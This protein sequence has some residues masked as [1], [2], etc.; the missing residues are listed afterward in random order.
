MRAIGKILKVLLI[1]VFTLALILIAGVFA[2]LKWPQLVVNDRVF[3]A[4]A[5]LSGKFGVMIAWDKSDLRVQSESL[6]HKRFD[7]A[8]DRFCVNLSENR[9]QGCFDRIELHAELA[10]L[11]RRFQAIAMG[12]ILATGGNVAV[13]LDPSDPRKKKLGLDVPD[14]VLPDWF[15]ATRFGRVELELKTL[16]LRQDD[17]LLFNG[18]ARLRAE[19]NER[20]RL[21]TARLEAVSLP[22]AGWPAGELQAEVKSESS[23]TENDWLL[24]GTGRLNPTR[25]ASARFGISL[26]PAGTKVYGIRLQGDFRLG[27]SSGSLNLNGLLGNGRLWGSFSGEG[28]GF[29]A[30][31]HRVAANSCRYD[32]R[33]TKASGRLRFSL[34]CPVLVDTTPLRIPS[35]TFEKLVTLPYNLD[36]RV[37][38]DLETSFY[39]SW[40]QPV[41]GEL[42]IDLNT[43]SENLLTVEGKTKTAFAGTPSRYPQ[44]WKLETD[45][46]VK[47]LMSQFQKLVKAL[48]RTAFAIFAPVNNLDGSVELKFTGKAD[49]AR[50]QGKLPLEFTTRLRSADQAF[51]TDGKGELQ[52]KLSKEGARTR[53]ALDLML[54]DAKLV[55]PSFGYT[56]MPALF[57]DPRFQTPDPAAKKRGG[58]FDYEL[59]VKTP[60]DKP[61]HLVS[62]FAKENIPLH[63]D[64]RAVPDRLSGTVAVGPSRLDFFRRD[65]QVQ[66]FV[67]TLQE[68]RERS[69]VDGTVKIRYADYD[70]RI[71]VVGTFK[72]PRIIMESSPPLDQEQIISVLIYGRTF[73]ELS[74]DNANSV[75][76][77]SSAV[78]NRAITLGSLFLL[79]GTPIESVSYDPMTQTFTARVRIAEG[80]SLTV[81]T[82]EGTSPQAGLR[83][84]LGRNWIL[85]TYVEDDQ[86][87]KAVRGGAMI[88]YYKRY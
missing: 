78:A 71:M 38:T 46:D 7:F 36:L 5:H 53:I 75:G 6:L 33:E 63:L 18:S 72:R 20:A 43:V 51:D 27:E 3:R 41:N 70:I 23:F 19:P 56:A 76:A 28:R 87:A 37:R 16:A 81:G 61:A 74:T 68:P 11:Q 15:R 32:L 86:K 31:V 13:V 88:E 55:L 47:I 66:K 12:P 1:T 54:S 14:L 67:F 82:K 84:N 50:Q 64:L 29:A 60:P 8:F 40:N 62:N 39:P 25:N 45:L 83:K 42:E 30:H 65:A 4:L 17:Q 59:T 24:T 48:D 44:G 10:W 58:N 22:G 9:R 35:P 73:D 57:S 2:I 80:T 77:V 52:Y 34:D 21:D 79:A 69:T 26:H 49:I 85:N